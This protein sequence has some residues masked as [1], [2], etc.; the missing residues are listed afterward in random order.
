[1]KSTFF[2]ILSGIKIPRSYFM[3]QQRSRRTFTED[4]VNHTVQLSTCVGFRE[5]RRSCSLSNFGGDFD[6]RSVTTY[7]R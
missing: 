2:K 5:R 1:M 3:L 7:T 4:K 6:P